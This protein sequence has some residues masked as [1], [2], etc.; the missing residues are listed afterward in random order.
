MAESTLA[1]Y[2]CPP[3]LTLAEM[4]EAMSLDRVSSD[5]LSKRHSTLGGSRLTLL[6]SRMEE[7]SGLAL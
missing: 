7:P 6:V 2:R 3:D 5:S 1:E 4:N